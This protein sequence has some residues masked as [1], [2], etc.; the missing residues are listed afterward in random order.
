MCTYTFTLDDRLIDRISPQFKEQE[1]MRQWLQQELEM[2][3]VQRAEKTADVQ[4]TQDK[5][6][7]R[8]QIL[9]LASGKRKP[10]L[11]SLKGIMAGATRSAEEMRSDYLTEKYGS[12]VDEFAGKWQDGRTTE[13]IVQ[14]IHDTI[15]G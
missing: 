4:K 14:D 2:L 8:K 6:L 13:Q 11:A 12:W 3:I 7:A 10:T 1:A 9:E 5:E 15:T